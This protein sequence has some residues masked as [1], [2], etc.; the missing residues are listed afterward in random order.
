MKERGIQ[1]SH[2]WEITFDIVKITCKT[3]WNG[4]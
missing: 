3:C 1:T 4:L 2:V